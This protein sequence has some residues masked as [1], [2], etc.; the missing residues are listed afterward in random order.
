[1]VIFLSLTH[2]LDR[3]IIEISGGGQLEIMAEKV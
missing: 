3:P 2:N 1:M